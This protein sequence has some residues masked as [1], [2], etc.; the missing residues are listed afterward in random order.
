MQQCSLLFAVLHSVHFDAH[1]LSG[2]HTVCGVRE[3]RLAHLFAVLTAGD[4]FSAALSNFRG[5][6]VW[7]IH[8]HH[9]GHAAECH[10]ERPDGVYTR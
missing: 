8:H 7:H 5:P 3:E 10:S 4:N 9:A 6:Y 1:A 2:G